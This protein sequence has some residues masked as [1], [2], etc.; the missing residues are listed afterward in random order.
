MDTER[1]MN[2]VS[3]SIFA[4]VVVI[5]AINGT[6]AYEDSQKSCAGV[7]LLPMNQPVYHMLFWEEDGECC[8]YELIEN[9]ITKGC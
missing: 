7:P 8:T 5:V 2:Y 9:R 3:L 6:T 4:I 1:L